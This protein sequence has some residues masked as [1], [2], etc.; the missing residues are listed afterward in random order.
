MSDYLEEPPFDEDCDE[1]GELMI[2]CV[3]EDDDEP[4]PGDV[5]DEDAE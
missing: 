2:N 3:C 1:C 5:E 4:Y